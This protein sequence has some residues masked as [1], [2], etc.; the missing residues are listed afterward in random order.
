MERR[1]KVRGD[2][3]TQNKYN[4]VAGDLSQAQHEEEHNKDGPGWSKGH[5][6]AEDAN[7][8]GGTKDNGFPAKPEVKNKIECQKHVLLYRYLCQRKEKTLLVVS[9]VAIQVNG[10]P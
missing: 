7:H 3:H 2:T 9:M 6:A 10:R 1:L 8:E 4:Y 5:C